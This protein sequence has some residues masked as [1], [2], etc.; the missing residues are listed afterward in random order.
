MSHFRTRD[1][2][3]LS[4]HIGRVLCEALLLPVMYWPKLR[5]VKA[6]KLGV[7]SK[8]FLFSK[9]V[10]DYWNRSADICLVMKAVGQAGHS[11]FAIAKISMS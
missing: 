1:H 6:K 11:L 5:V 8:I 7:R 10:Q 4:I 2:E 3:D 9:T